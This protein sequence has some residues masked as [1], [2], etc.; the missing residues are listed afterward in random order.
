MACV[1]GRAPRH[2]LEEQKARSNRITCG[3]VS[4]WSRAQVHSPTDVLHHGRRLGS[5][6]AGR[7]GPTGCGAP[8][9]ADPIMDRRPFP[10]CRSLVL[11]LS[12]LSESRSRDAVLLPRCNP[13]TNARIRVA[14]DSDLPSGDQTDD[15]LQRPPWSW[16]SA[17]PAGLR[18]ARARA[19][20]QVLQ[21]NAIAFIGRSLPCC[22][23][24]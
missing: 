6:R 18:D 9:R 8:S 13:A 22:L 3:E 19:I 10:N 1:R 16:S 15:F 21:W 11:V 12:A 14:R 7:G 4:S 2:L 5:V 17:G 20:P 23:W 24:G